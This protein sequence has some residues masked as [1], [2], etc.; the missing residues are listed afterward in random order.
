MPYDELPDDEKQGNRDTARET[1]QVVVAL[2]YTVTPPGDVASDNHAYGLVPMPVDETLRVIRS[3]ESSL[4]LLGQIWNTRSH[5]TWATN[6]PLFEQL[7]SRLVG[8]GHPLLAYDVASQGLKLHPDSNPLRLAMAIIQGRLGE[9]DAARSYAQQVLERQPDNFEAIA[10]I[11]SAHKAAW[12]ET[13]DPALKHNHLQ[14]AIKFY[15]RAFSVSQ[16]YWPAINAATLLAIAGDQPA[17]HDWRIARWR[18]VARMW[19]LPATVAMNFGCKPPSPKPMPC[20]AIG[21]RRS[22]T[23]PWQRKVPAARL[24]G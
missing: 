16:Q 20:S 1:L 21:T 7:A 12:R 17:A 15:Q 13:K 24:A 14:Q 10:Q 2:G 18:R 23:M 4:E 6:A 22:K 3:T 5:V 11:A 9:H 19:H 8:K